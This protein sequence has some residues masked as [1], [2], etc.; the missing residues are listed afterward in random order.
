MVVLS[1]DWCLAFIW[2][3]GIR[4]SWRLKIPQRLYWDDIM[5]PSE[6]SLLTD[7]WACARAAAGE[8]R[9]KSRLLL[10]HLCVYIDQRG[11]PLVLLFQ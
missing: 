8:S 2:H 7:G 11:L 5:M 6:F 10:F 9:P 4:C 1:S 3:A